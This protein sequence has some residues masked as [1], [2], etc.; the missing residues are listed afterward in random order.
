MHYRKEHQFTRLFWKRREK[1][2]PSVGGEEKN[3]NVR[4]T[5]QHYFL[6]RVP[7]QVKS[8]TDAK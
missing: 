4:E 6:L 7:L 8:K 3:G 5:V 1:H 2:L